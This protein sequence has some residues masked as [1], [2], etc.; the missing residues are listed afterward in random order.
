MIRFYIEKKTLSIVLKIKIVW[1]EIDN[2]K[3]PMRTN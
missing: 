1:K 2:K 3:S